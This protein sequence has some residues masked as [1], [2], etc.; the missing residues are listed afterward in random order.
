VGEA[1]A[2]RRVVDL[3]DV[4]RAE[5]LMPA[6]ES[7]LSDTSERRF[8]AERIAA[9]A[10]GADTP[11]GGRRH[12]ESVGVLA[13]L[14]VSEQDLKPSR[15]LPGL[16]ARLAERRAKIGRTA[17]GANVQVPLLTPAELAALKG[18]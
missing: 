8:A 2:A 12:L 9:F 11:A 1:I 18:R 13:T 16:R 7:A 4:S 6:L 14:S 10:V 3:N 15:R 17:T 5:D